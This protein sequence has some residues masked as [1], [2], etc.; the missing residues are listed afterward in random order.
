MT[1]N[2]AGTLRVRIDGPTAGA[3]YDQLRP[4]SATSGTTLAGTLDL[5]AAPS[6]AAGDTYRI[7]DNTG[8]STAIT[9]TFAGLPEGAEFHEAAQWWRISYT[10]GTGNDVVLT[11]INPITATAWQ[12]WQS[13]NFG[14]NANAPPIA[15][16]LAD[17]DRDLTSN[18][19]EYATGMN[20]SISDRV[21]LS[22]VKNGSAI[23]FI[24][25]RNNAATDVSYTV[26]WTENFTTWST[27]G[28]TSTVLSDNGT[29]RQ[30][31]AAVPAD[32]P[33]TGRFV[34]LKVTRP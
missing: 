20:P 31:K 18:L 25:T 1:V 12:T 26:E 30:I 14:A 13:A 27:I 8:S 22:A 33:H 32:G 17:H 11:R 23:D 19:M 3:Q 28:V 21:P 7:I 16:D 2:A 5:I 6:L 4:T 34:R 15:G 10:G 9:G 29:T 24:H